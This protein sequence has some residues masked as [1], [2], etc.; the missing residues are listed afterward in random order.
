MARK[1]K[2][3]VDLKRE[4][5]QLVLSGRGRVSEVSREH[6][7]HPSLACWPRNL[8]FLATVVRWMLRSSALLRKE[9]ADVRS[10]PNG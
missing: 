6:E 2:H 10:L 7:I 9:T 8:S 3:S 4:I 1:K 5:V